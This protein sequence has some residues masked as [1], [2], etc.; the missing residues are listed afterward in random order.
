[1]PKAIRIREVGGPEVLR[2]EDVAVG[3]PGEG[4]ARVRHAAV[5][6]N[7]VDTYHRTGLYKAPLPT[8]LGVEAAGVVEAVGK[9]V[10]HVR[11]GDRV[12]YAGGPPGAYAESRVVAAD[13]LLKLPPEITDQ[14]AAAGL[15]KGLTVW[16]LV[17]RVHRVEPG[18]TVLFHAA[19]GGVGLLAMQWLRALGARVIAT[20][21]SDEKASL[22]RAHGADEV[23]VYTREDFTRRARELT[24]G[25]G[26]PVVYDSVGRATFE[27]SLDSLRQAG[28]MVSFG[29]AS[30]PVPP[31]D[32]AQLAAKGSLFLTRP[33]LFNY[34]AK[35]SDLEEGAR[36]LFQ[37]MVTGKVKV[38]APR[39]WPLAQAAEA[40]RALEGRKTTGSLVLL[41]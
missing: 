28:L 10:S 38:G 2:L 27:G 12:G 15:L 35:R 24:G 20:A 4:E 30:G 17:R 40:H 39:S 32:I 6:V 18:E 19:V 21:G 37:M 41:P 1:M 29:N 25:A 33:T 13:R 8:G 5:G 14:A 34:T 9:G 36:E 23:I 22:A 26:V 3:E 31:F 7:Y 11:P 16:M